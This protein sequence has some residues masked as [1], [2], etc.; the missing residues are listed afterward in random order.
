MPKGEVDPKW[1][2][3]GLFN[4]SFEFACGN[5]Q[6]P[7]YGLGPQLPTYQTM[8]KTGVAEDINFAILNGD[9]LYE[10]RRDYNAMQWAAK[11]DVIKFTPDDTNVGVPIFDKL[12]HP[13]KLF[14]RVPAE[15]ETS[16]WSAKATND[17]PRDPDPYSAAHRCLGELQ[18]VP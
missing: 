18:V 10:I 2:P 6:I 4:F 9:W 5:N 13:E 8:M 15:D 11:H 16:A 1:N 14:K 17:F 12:P 7:R 3:D